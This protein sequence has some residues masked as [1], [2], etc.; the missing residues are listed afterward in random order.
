MNKMHHTAIKTDRENP[1]PLPFAL[2]SGGGGGAR[3]LWGA[4]AS[5]RPREDPASSSGAWGT[6]GAPP[7]PCSRC[8]CCLAS[9]RSGGSCCCW[10]LCKS[11]SCHETY[12]ITNQRRHW[13]LSESKQ[14]QSVSVTSYARQNALLVSFLTRFSKGTSPFTSTIT[15]FCLPHLVPTNSTMLLL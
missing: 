8:C 15:K 14:I 3:G 1:R 9:C 5:P 4:G 11:R 6:T 12:N 2:T 7:R 10:L 13:F